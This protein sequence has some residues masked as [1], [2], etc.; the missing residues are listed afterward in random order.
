MTS[1]Y[2]LAPSSMDFPVNA[3][4]FLNDDELV[5]ELPGNVRL[6]HKDAVCLA[7]LLWS[8]GVTVSEVV[9]LDWHED[10]SRAPLNGQKIAI[11]QRLRLLEQSED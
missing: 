2:Y 6:S 9:M 10:A 5:A 8:K 1:T 11:Y 3:K 7:D 4:I